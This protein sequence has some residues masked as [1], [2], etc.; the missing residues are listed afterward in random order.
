MY[1]CDIIRGRHTCDRTVMFKKGFSCALWTFIS[2]LN[3]LW[4]SC[5]FF[6]CFSQVVG[7]FLL[8]DPRCYMRH[9]KLRWVFERYESWKCFILNRTDEAS[10]RVMS[11]I[12]A[13][14][15]FR[16]A[17]LHS[18]ANRESKTSCSSVQ[19]GRSHCCTIMCSPYVILKLWYL[20]FPEG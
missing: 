11:T 4:S 7:H 20:I 10:V 14:L 6:E 1:R 2:M 3:I 5:M 12:A 17:S 13:I 16:N 9:T 18:V 8:S 19:M 15:L